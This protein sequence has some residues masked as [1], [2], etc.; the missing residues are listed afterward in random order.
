MIL[1]KINGL[2]SPTTVVVG[3]ARGYGSPPPPPS[4]FFGSYFDV[5]VSIYLVVFPSSQIRPHQ[6]SSSTQFSQE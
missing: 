2:G 3:G 1:N 4:R 6:S 5:I